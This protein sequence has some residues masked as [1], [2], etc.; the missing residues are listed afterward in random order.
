MTFEVHGIEKRR[1]RHINVKLYFLCESTKNIRFSV[2]WSARSRQVGFN[3]RYWL[4]CQWLYRP[5]FLNLR[6]SRTKI[7]NLKRQSG[8]DFN[9]V[10]FRKFVTSLVQKLKI[11]G[12]YKNCK[13][14]YWLQI[15]FLPNILKRTYLMSL[16]ICHF[17]CSIF[18]LETLKFGWQ[19]SQYLELNPTCA[20]QTFAVL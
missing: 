3:S 11:L 13:S 5:F 1:D 2:T 8:R 19:C 10:I 17:K 6:V 4:H 12:V 14:R 15:S 16:L 7:E 20:H 18:V 9:K